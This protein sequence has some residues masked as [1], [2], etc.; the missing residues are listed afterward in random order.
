MA[1]RLDTKAA[2]ASAVPTALGLAWG[3][4]E[5]RV[6]FRRQ[7]AALE[8]D[9]ARGRL[10]IQAASHDPIDVRI[11]EPVAALR[12]IAEA[13]RKIVAITGVDRRDCLL[14]SPDSSIREVRDLKS[15]RI[16]I[17]RPAGEA[18]LWP[19]AD[20]ERVRSA[21]LASGLDPD[22]VRLVGLP[23]DDAELHEPGWSAHRVLRALF[24]R[25]VDAV[26]AEAVAGAALR[27]I[28]GLRLLERWPAANDDGAAYPFSRQWRLVTIPAALQEAQRA[29]VDRLLAHA[30]AAVRWAGRHPAE[31]GRLLAREYGIAE[32]E[33]ASVYPGFASRELELDIMDTKRE[34]IERIAGLMRSRGVPAAPADLEAAIDPERL[35]E[36]RSLAEQGKIGQPSAEGVSAYAIA[37]VPA[38]YF[39][40]RGRARRIGGDAEALEAAAAYADQIRDGA[41]DRDRYRELPFAEVRQLKESGLLGLAVPK[42]YGGPGVSTRTLIEVFKIVSAADG[43]IGQIP[44]NHHFFVKSVELVGSERQ[45]RFFFDE[46]LRGAQF[47]NALAERG[48]RSLK[49]SSTRL[50]A[51][52]PG[53]YRLSG[54]KYYTT[55]ALFADWIPVTALDEEEHRVTAFVPRQARGVTVIDDWSGVGQRTTASGTVILR[56]VE[57][58]Q[59]HVLPHWQ[60]FERPQVFS[61]FGQIMH[62]AIDIGIAKA[63]LADAAKFVREKTRPPMKSNYERA[64]DDPD[65]I[66]R[67]GELGIRLS[68]AEALLEKAADLIDE[69]E[70]N[71]NAETAGRAT[72]AVDS[73]KY[74]ATEAAIEVTNALFEVAGTSSMDRVYNLDRHRRNVRIH[75]LHDPA[76]LKLHHTGKWFLNGVYH[77]YE[78]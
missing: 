13:N 3:L 43:S 40:G 31:A 38:E 8:F 41:S 77:V 11:D 37:D 73:A 68:A 45:K 16:G 54:N 17:A 2:A 30:L 19:D 27:R 44:Q 70:A 75:T 74:A 15:A 39:A 1:I 18:G 60:I 50:T 10:T 28:A 25:E 29:L 5:V 32:R 56:D 23:A 12:S 78:V 72:L 58:P 69:A 61:A 9:A 67:F 52:G 62:A 21:L 20:T 42:A 47:G 53:R 66:R 57:V 24:S 7:G 35:E 49:M 76:R 55:G 26:L 22:D 64:S 65:L 6:D 71:L 48:V 33:W 14:V 34:A 59:E 46:V 36:A 63:A 51:A 4:G